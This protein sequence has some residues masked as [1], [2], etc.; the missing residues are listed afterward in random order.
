MISSLAYA[1]LGTA[2]QVFSPGPDGGR[3]FTFTG[4]IAGYEAQDW[5]GFLVIQAK[6]HERPEGRSKDVSWLL[7]QLKIMAKFR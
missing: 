3:D 2:G 6:Y 7:R 5:S 1:E 4:K